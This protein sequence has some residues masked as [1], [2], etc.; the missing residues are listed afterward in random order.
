MLDRNPSYVILQ[1]VQQYLP[2]L[3]PVFQRSLAWWV[4]G[5]GLAKSCLE[6]QV[7]AS[8]AGYAKA[9]TIRARLREYCYDGAHRAAPCGVSLDVASCFAPLVRWVLAWWQGPDVALAI[10]ATTVRDR[11][12]VLVVSVL[13]RGTALPV[14]WQVLP[15]Q[16][17]GG[18][19]APL[20]R[21]LDLIAPVLRQER[22]RG[23]RL[24]MLV[25]RGLWSPVL[26]KAIQEAGAHPVMRVPADTIV[27]PVHPDWQHQTPS[28]SPRRR[29]ISTAQLAP[30]PAQAWIG[31]AQVFRDRAKRLPAT[32]AVLHLGDQE[33][34]VVLTDLPVSD[35]DPCWYGLRMWIEAGFRGMKSFGWNWERTRRTDPMR[36][37]RHLLAL[38][39]TMILT[40]AYGTR[41]EDAERLGVDPGVLRRPPAVPTG[42]TAAHH[43]RTAILRLGRTILMRLARLGRTWKGVWL[44]PDPW[45][46]LPATCTVIRLLQP[47]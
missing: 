42:L 20:V 46:Q 43:R 8:L 32:V 37:S 4:L 12:T 25:D 23:R 36:A 28:V 33:P 15:G 1:R 2:Q 45:P 6:P 29:R 22:A 16:T 38:A 19:L 18:W 34:L 30:E 39:V 10:D 35:I 27:R 5:M 44:T 31:E 47:T 26:W 3:R 24:L 11:L 40:A 17:K 14:A 21:V 13:Y 7:V 41:V 9:E